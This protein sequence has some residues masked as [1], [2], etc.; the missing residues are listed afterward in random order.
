MSI[1]EKILEAKR[2]EIEE[3]KKQ[4]PLSLLQ[5]CLATRKPIRDFKASLKGKGIQLIGE[6]KKTSPTQGVLRKEFQP[7]ALALAYQKGG[8]AS[9]S[10]LTD[11]SFF[12]GHLSDIREIKSSVVLPILRKDFILDEY[13]LYESAEAESD[14]ILLISTLL[15]KNLLAQLIQQS[16]ELGMSSLVE[17]HSEEDLQK[18]LGA[19]A[20]LIGIN[21]RNLRTFEMDLS[22]SE[23]LMKHIPKEK[24]VVSESG[25]HSRE[26]VR[27]L[28]ELGFDAVLIGQAFMERPNLE[29]AIHEVMGR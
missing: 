13:Q 19:G 24:T 11:E 10:V 17:V 15:S 16:A 18:A 5:K 27:R 7:V 29:E 26:E 6:I 2:K 8:A 21:N 20:E 4:N 25:I 23:R 3:R 1:L 28:E 22:T 9:L 14:A 12:G